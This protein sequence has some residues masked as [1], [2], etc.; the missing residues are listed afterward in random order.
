MGSARRAVLA[1]CLI[2]TLV[3]IAGC[4]SGGSSTTPKTRPRT[5]T[6]T[7]AKV[8]GV[9]VNLMLTGSRTAVVTGSKGTCKIPPFGA[10][11][12]DFEGSDYPS[13]G[14]DGSL[15][16]IGPIV[17][18]NG[19]TVPPTVKIIMGDVG[20]L[21][22][23]NGAGITVSQNKRNVTL[24]ADVSGGPGVTE[25][26]SLLPPDASLHAHISGTIRCT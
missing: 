1:G 12:Y 19:G 15:S 5:T 14:P 25:D 9:Q 23:Q 7:A 8:K 6:P 16:V 2:G 20:L 21:T 4:S 11:T 3:V 18:A 10:P 26:N 13:L 17:V 24:D 22:P